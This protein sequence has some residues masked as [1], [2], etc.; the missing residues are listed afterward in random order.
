[1]NIIYLTRM[2]VHVM[3][4]ICAFRGEISPIQNNFVLINSVMAESE[5]RD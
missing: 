3:K 1:L 5:K 2:G 4:A